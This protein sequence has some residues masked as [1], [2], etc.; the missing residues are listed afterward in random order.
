MMKVRSWIL[1]LL[2]VVMATQLFAS[3]AI[4]ATT[5]QVITNNDVTRQQENTPP[6][7]NWVLYT[8]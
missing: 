5:T 3:D 6:T 8:R 7:D 2:T 4:A 1:V